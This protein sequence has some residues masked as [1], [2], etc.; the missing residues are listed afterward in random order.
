MRHHASLGLDQYAE[1]LLIIL[2]M[3]C[4]R[5]FESWMEGYV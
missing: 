4:I 2:K 1:G 3:V 5:F